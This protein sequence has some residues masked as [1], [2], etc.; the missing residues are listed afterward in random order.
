M[1]GSRRSF[2]PVKMETLTSVLRVSASQWGSWGSGWCKPSGIMG[3]LTLSWEQ[4]TA[5][6]L[7]GNKA[8]QSCPAME[9]LCVMWCCAE[10]EWSH[11]DRCCSWLTCHLQLEGEVTVRWT[12]QARSSKERGRDW[13]NAISLCNG[14]NG[15]NRNGP[16]WLV[17]LLPG[18]GSVKYV[19]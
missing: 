10:E 2:G 7:R 18:Q 17:M 3:P 15:S 19:P 9:E 5:V 4:P 11:F 8:P 13:S 12:P 16:R 14:T 1:T 6:C